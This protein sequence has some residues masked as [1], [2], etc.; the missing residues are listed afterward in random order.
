MRSREEL[1][2]EGGGVETLRL[3]VTAQVIKGQRI[4]MRKNKCIVQH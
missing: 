3:A 4:E 1:K 2:L